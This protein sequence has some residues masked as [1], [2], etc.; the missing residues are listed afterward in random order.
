LIDPRLRTMS[1]YRPPSLVEI[2]GEFI[3]TADDSIAL[4]RTE[5]FAE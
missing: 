4:S 2:E 5:I 3:S 1:V